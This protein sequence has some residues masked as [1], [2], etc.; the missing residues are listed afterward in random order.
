MQEDEFFYKVE[1]KVMGNCGDCIILVMEDMLFFL[2]VKKLDGYCLMDKIEYDI[3]MIGM[4][5]EKIGILKQ[6]N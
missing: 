2:K 5:L 3:K 4:G 1:D 6:D